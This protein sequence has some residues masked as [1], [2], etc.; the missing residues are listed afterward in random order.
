M[1]IARTIDAL[2]ELDR[3]EAMSIEYIRGDR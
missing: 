3:R 2:K 1:P